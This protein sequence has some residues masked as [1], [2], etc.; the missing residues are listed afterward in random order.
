MQIG[1]TYKTKY[2]FCKKKL[3][4]I[5]TVTEDLELKPVEKLEIIYNILTAPDIYAGEKDALRGH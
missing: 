5:L 1:K 2:H 4:D 3:E